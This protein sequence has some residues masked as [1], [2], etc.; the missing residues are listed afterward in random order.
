LSK[1]PDYKNIATIRGRSFPY[2]LLSQNGQT[3]ISNRL[4]K[5]NPFKCNLYYAMHLKK[6]SEYI[7]IYTY[8]KN[9]VFKRFIFLNIH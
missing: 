1:H 6:R 7:N 4:D 3:A 8:E 5:Y 2:T 9:M